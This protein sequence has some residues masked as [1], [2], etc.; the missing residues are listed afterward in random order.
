LNKKFL[1]HSYVPVLFF[2]AAPGRAQ[3]I[4][5]CLLPVSHVLHQ[6]ETTAG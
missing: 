4:E 1:N 6:N 3:A 5:K 2:A